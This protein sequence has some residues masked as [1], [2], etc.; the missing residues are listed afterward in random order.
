[1]TS[2]REKAIEAIRSVNCE[3]D[4]GYPSAYD[5]A[6]IVDALDARGLLR[7]DDPGDVVKA[8]AA[9]V[10]EHQPELWLRDVGF[11]TAIQMMMRVAKGEPEDPNWQRLAEDPNWR[12]LVSEQNR[13]DA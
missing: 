6:Q 7:D 11:H 5:A 2:I 10:I 1:M 9:R 12:R 13:E 4:V 8:V 3:L